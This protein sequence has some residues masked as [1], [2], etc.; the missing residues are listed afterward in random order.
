MV[1]W[2]APPPAFEAETLADLAPADARTDAAPAVEA[3]PE[4]VAVP[5]QTLTDAEEPTPSTVD[6][7]PVAGPDIDTAS[8]AFAAPSEAE[9]QAEAEAEVE[10]AEPET[11]TKQRPRRGISAIVAGGIAEALARA[12]DPSTGELPPAEF[13]EGVRDETEPGLDAAEAEPVEA[14][15]AEQV[16]AVAVPEPG[17]DM[18]A[19]PSVT[20][21]ELAEAGPESDELILGAPES[22]ESADEELVAPGPEVDQSV[23]SADI[24]EPDW[25]V[26]G[27]YTWL[28]AAQ[29]EQRGEQDEA[30]ADEEQPS[31]TFT[32]AELAADDEQAASDAF[33]D[34]EASAVDELA[35]V[36]EPEPET[37]Q[38]EPGTAQPDADLAA[39]PEAASPL[40][41]AGDEESGASAEPEQEL[42]EET[43]PQAAPSFE[44]EGDLPPDA[45]AVEDVTEPV[46]TEAVEPAQVVPGAEPAG[47]NQPE[48]ATD[49]S[50]AVAGEDASEG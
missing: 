26:E 35:P 33:T 23:Y 4:P 25:L 20:A 6:V 28:D 7:E 37:G 41:A 15:M 50:E 9:A 2:H 32:Q 24:E 22:D 11:E 46:D 5:D 42:M 12:I 1:E 18:T 13:A 44:F 47:D 31:N 36:G 43:A 3:T 38:P 48:A 19:E 16:E 40:A 17:Q 27:E 39:E 10:V 30:A 29:A 49:A 21:A 14:V 8:D 34:P 45:I